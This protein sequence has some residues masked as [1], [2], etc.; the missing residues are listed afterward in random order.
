MLIIYPTIGL[1]IDFDFNISNNLYK[2]LLE[3]GKNIKYKKT[4][5]FFKSIT[6]RDTNKQALCYSGGVDSTA[7]SIL[8]PK[9]TVHVFLDRI[10]P[11][12]K[13]NTIYHKDQIYFSLDCLLKTGVNVISVK[14]DLEW[15][16]EKLQDL[17]LIF[18]GVP[19]I[20]LSQYN[21]KNINGRICKT[22]FTSNY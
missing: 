9:T 15:M 22:S 10:N 20:I 11:I 6:K 3:S 4:K 1:E 2:T 16:D 12:S 21:Y 18:C 8:P 7:A 14:T 17:Y 5:D 13:K 19:S